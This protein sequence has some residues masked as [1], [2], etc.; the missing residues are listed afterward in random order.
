MLGSFVRVVDC[1]KLHK[2]VHVIYVPSTGSAC[3]RAYIFPVVKNVLID[4]SAHA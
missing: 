4:V 1:V 2:T 3:R